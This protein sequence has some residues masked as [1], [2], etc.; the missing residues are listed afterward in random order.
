VLDKIF[1]S[2]VEATEEATINALVA[3]ET[4]TGKNGNT[5]YSIPHDQV[6]TML[7]KYNRLVEK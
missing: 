5:F 3:A 4:M 6:K 1:K 7:K 2:T